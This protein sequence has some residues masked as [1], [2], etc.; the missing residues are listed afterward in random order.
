MLEFK[1]DINLFK[2]DRPLSAISVI[3]KILERNL[4][5]QIASY[6]YKYFFSKPLFTQKEQLKLKNIWSVL[7]VN[8][9]VNT[10]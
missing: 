9:N 1:K 4:P 2:N 8:Y 3:S 7:T 10:P 6:I 5:K